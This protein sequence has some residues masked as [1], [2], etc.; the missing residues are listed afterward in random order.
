[1]A[2]MLPGRPSP[3]SISIYHH[4]GLLA[5]TASLASHTKANIS[6]CHCSEEKCVPEVT[7]EEEVV[8]LEPS[9]I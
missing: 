6:F 4:A 8:S 1:M 9:D 7:C 2:H 3:G 5:T